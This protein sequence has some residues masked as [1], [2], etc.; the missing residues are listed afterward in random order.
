ME[1]IDNIYVIN[2]KKDKEKLKS[3]KD[4]LAKVTN[5]G[6]TR[7]DA[8]YGKDVDNETKKNITN[9][10]CNYFCTDTMIGCSLSHMKTWKQIV[11][12]DDDYALVLEDD[13]TFERDFNTKLNN[14]IAELN[15][16]DSDWD[17]LY[18]NCYGLCDK[19]NDYNFINRLIYPF[20][21]KIENDYFQTND[22]KHFFVPERPLST[23]CYIISKRG[24]KILSE[25]IQLVEGHID[26]TM[27]KNFTGLNIYASNE[28]LSKQNSNSET[29]SQFNA[30]PISLNKL[31]NKVNCNKDLTCSYAAGVPIG[32]ILGIEINVYFALFL[33]TALLIPKRETRNYIQFL[34]VFFIL[35]LLLNFRNI[36][37]VIFYS[38]ITIIILKLRNIKI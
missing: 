29:S 12:N 3:I 5:K 7:I 31:L 18:L 25:R 16:K 15:E 37:Y 23:G 8:I 30:F 10:F 21:K 4:E 9:T 6:F 38:T 19:D 27:N 32:K 35:E 1:Y 11:E 14:I 17:I 13:A 24:A 36:K 20:V 34:C 28:M 2:L 22:A 33:I 26:A